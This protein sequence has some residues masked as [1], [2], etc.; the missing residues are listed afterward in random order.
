MFDFINMFTLRRTF[1]RRVFIF[2]SIKL[3]TIIIRFGFCLGLL[4]F[5]RKLFLQKIPKYEKHAS[6]GV[7]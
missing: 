2:S 7:E 1:G 3:F 4:I 5:N 6:T